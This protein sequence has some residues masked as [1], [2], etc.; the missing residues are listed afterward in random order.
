MPPAPMAISVSPMVNPSRESS[1]A[2]AKCPAQYTKER[3]MM[4]LYLPR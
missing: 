1:S 2:N 4:V 3:L